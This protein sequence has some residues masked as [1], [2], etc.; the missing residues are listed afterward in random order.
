MRA[1]I[2]NACGLY[3]AGEHKGVKSNELKIGALSFCPTHVMQKGTA[4]TA[5]AIILI[6][7]GGRWII[8][9]IQTHSKLLLLWI[10][11]AFFGLPSIYTKEN[12]SMQI[13]VA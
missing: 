6:G 12:L 4:R 1:N 13:T 2:I 8:I 5:T 9:V 3:G 11:L 10:V 7:V